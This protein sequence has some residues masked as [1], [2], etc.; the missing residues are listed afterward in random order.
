MCSCA[1]LDVS[2]KY[3]DSILSGLYAFWQNI[4]RSVIFFQYP[5]SFPFSLFRLRSFFIK[6]RIESWWFLFLYKIF[7]KKNWFSW[8]IVMKFFRSRSTEADKAKRSSKSPA[9]AR[10]HSG[11]PPPLDDRPRRD[12]S[13]DR[14][15]SRSPPRRSY[16]PPPPRHDGYHRD[17]DTRSGHQ[18]HF[19]FVFCFDQGSMLKRSV[20]THPFKD[21][22]GAFFTVKKSPW[23]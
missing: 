4:D 7:E 14:R 12:Y 5:F 22:W 23:D 13:P 19:N 11:S 15:Y 21:P 3:D 20:L 9:P 17:Y 16:S 1:L 6:Y 10:K 2:V 18:S 8:I